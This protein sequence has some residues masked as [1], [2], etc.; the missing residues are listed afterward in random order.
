MPRRNLRDNAATHDLVSDFASRP[1]ADGAVFRLFTSQRH[2]L[3]GLLGRDLGMSAWTRDI[4]EALF[5]RQIVQ[6]SRLQAEPAGAP[7]AHR[8]HTEAQ[9]AGHL[10][11]IL[12]RGRR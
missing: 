10:R 3:A 6:A 4:L 12:A 9:V 11:G 1:L 5:H 8:I 7:Q 2:Y